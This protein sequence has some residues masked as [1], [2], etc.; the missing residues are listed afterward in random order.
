MI[1]YQLG[2]SGTVIRVDPSGEVW[3]IPPDPGNADYQRFRDWVAAGNVPTPPV[4]HPGP[5]DLPQA[6]E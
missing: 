4:E 6:T 1:S 5:L 2:P 3:H